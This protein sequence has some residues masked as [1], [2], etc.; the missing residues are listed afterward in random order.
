MFTVLFESSLVLVVGVRVISA[1]VDAFLCLMLRI[2]RCSP[3]SSIA[4]CSERLQAP[5]GRF[6]WRHALVSCL[7]AGSVESK[8]IWL[9]LYLVTRVETEEKGYVNLIKRILNRKKLANSHSFLPVWICHVIIQSLLPMCL[10][11]W[12]SCTWYL[13][14][15]RPQCLHYFTINMPCPFHKIQSYPHGQQG[16]ISQQH[17]GA[18]CLDCTTSSGMH[19][20]VDH[21]NAPNTGNDIINQKSFSKSMTVE[22]QTIANWIVHIDLSAWLNSFSIMIKRSHSPFTILHITDWSWDKT[23]MSCTTACNN[24]SST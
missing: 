13:V 11:H 18:S 2:L 7:N 5:T 17:L 22:I 9:L 10:A 14:Y 23:A 15:S 21:W 8:P 1:K 4:K 12:S 16:G 24:T 19:P 20:L 3:L 6:L